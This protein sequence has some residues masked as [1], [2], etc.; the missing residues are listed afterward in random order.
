MLASIY[1]DRFQHMS[2]HAGQT[3]EVCEVECYRSSGPIA[4]S[5]RWN[6]NIAGSCTVVT[7]SSQGLRPCEDRAGQPASGSQS[8]QGSFYAAL[9]KRPVWPAEKN[10]APSRTS[11]RW[12]YG[13]YFRSRRSSIERAAHQ[14]EGAKKTLGIGGRARG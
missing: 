7:F 10:S 6:A 4:R 14:R 5:Y 11:V 2:I 3:Y 1:L 12:R 9:P 8:T 13:R